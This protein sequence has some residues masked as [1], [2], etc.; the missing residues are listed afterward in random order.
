MQ[1]NNVGEIARLYPAV[2]AP[3]P[4]MIAV[5][6]VAIYLGQI[7]YCVMLVLARKPE[8][9]ASIPYFIAMVSLR[10]RCREHLSKVLDFRLSLLIGLWRRG[11]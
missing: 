11:R 5:Y 4:R 6:L 3:E 1:V 8:T 7:G 10:R 2:I 9:K